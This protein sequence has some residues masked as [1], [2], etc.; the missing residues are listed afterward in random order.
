VQVVCL[1]EYDRDLMLLRFGEHA[2]SPRA[3]HAALEAAGAHGA[4]G[5][6]AALRAIERAHDVDLGEICHRFARRD[7]P[8]THP[9]ERFVIGYIA[10]ERARPDGA[11]QLW[12]RVD[13]IQ[14]VRALMHGPAVV[15]PS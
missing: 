13:R 4:A 5:R 2:N 15:E 9:I 8:A 10:E 12:V 7:D 14:Q 1:S 3:L 11:A 6:S